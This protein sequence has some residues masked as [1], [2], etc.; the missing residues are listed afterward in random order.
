MKAAQEAAL[1]SFVHGVQRA[2][3]TSSALAFIASAVALV[4]LRRLP[5]VA[6]SRRGLTVSSPRGASSQKR[7]TTADS[8]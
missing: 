2:L 4:G 5:P 8:Q 1:E 7:R 6:G 3:V